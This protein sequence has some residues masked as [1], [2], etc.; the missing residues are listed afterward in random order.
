VSAGGGHDAVLVV[1]AGG[2]ALEQARD[3]QTRVSRQRCA[4]RARARQ[5]RD[6]GGS[7]QPGASSG[8]RSGP[9]ARVEQ[10]RGKAR[11]MAAQE[12]EHASG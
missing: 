12:C 8:A 11:L 1:H 3:R 5:V 7:E 10:Q 9:G 4:G 6:P 2:Q